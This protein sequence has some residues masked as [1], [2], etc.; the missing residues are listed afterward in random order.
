MGPISLPGPGG[1]APT[2]TEKPHPSH[3]DRASGALEDDRIQN[4]MDLST[5]DAN[6]V[7]NSPPGDREA[8]TGLVLFRIQGFEWRLETWISAGFP[9]DHYE[10]A[11]SRSIPV[12]EAVDTVRRVIRAVL[13]DSHTRLRMVTRREGRDRP[14]ALPPSRERV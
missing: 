14:R 8:F 1:L 5:K 4:H 11:R 6:T 2:V 9:V 13:R 7:Q 10:K 12:M 3:P